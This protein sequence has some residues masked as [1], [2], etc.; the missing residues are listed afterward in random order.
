MSRYCKFARR[1]KGFVTVYV[2]FAT[3][4]MLPVAGL[5]IDMGVLYL[6]KARLQQAADA[7]V[8]GAGALV[9]RSTNLED[10]AQ[11]AAI[12]AATRRYFNAN[13]DASF[14]RS[15]QVSYS[16]T[17]V[18]NETKLRTITVTATYKVP[19]M[20]LR[21]LKLF[22]ADVSESTV[23][24][25]AEAKIRFVNMVMV[26]DR[27]GSVQRVGNGT[28]ITNALRKFVD[29]DP[30]IDKDAAGNPIQP[31][32]HDGRDVVGLLTY[33]TSWRYDYPLDTNF[34]TQSGTHNRIRTTISAVDYAT[35]ASTN[36]ADGLFHAFRYLEDRNEP[37]ALNVILLL[38]DGRPSAFSGS[39]S[40]K[41]SSTCSVKT[42]K[43][44]VASGSVQKPWPPSSTATTTWGLYKT[45]FT[46]NGADDTITPNS[47]NC[48]YKSDPTKVEND[49]SQI[50]AM[51]QPPDDNAAARAF[52]TQTGYAPTAGAGTN[53][54]YTRQV[55]YASV[56]VADNV[57]TMIRQNTVIRPVLYVIG[58]NVPT[59]STEEPLD[60]D[61]LARVANDPSW[62][63]SVTGARVFQS[64]Q[65]PG[66]YYNVSNGSGLEAALQD[67]TAQILRLSM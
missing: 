17:A 15:T 35:N 62:I 27:S 18:Q 4:L 2:A 31:I 11:K 46:A 42:A 34:Q 51:V 12:E 10:T 23:G 1:S 60:A 52:N 33:G 67:I 14:W 37:G 39:F 49:V 36:T 56:N 26:V 24:V 41:T 50:P 53:I 8:I 25:K 55:R 58:L 40:I 66:R 7:A 64:A 54:M 61:W 43:P 5:A 63:S 65:T 30:T 6:V 3:F 44:G 19:L 22:N 45:T 47:T 48:A 13:Y 29:P 16:G 9:Q 59:T 28:V 32:F 20:F 57:A 21:T 38:T